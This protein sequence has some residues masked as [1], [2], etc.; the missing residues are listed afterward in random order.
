L[1]NSVV[2]WYETTFKALLTAKKYKLA[3]QFLNNTNCQCGA[4]STLAYGVCSD[5][6]SKI[7]HAKKS[8]VLYGAMST[9]IEELRTDIAQFLWDEGVR[10]D[11]NEV[12]YH[13]A[14]SRI[15]DHT[16]EELSSTVKWLRNLSIEVQL[17][18]VY[19]AA[20]GCSISYVGSE[21]SRQYMPTGREHSLDIIKWL[22]SQ[23][24][25]FP[26][27]DDAPS[28]FVTSNDILE[29]YISIGEK[30]EESHLEFAARY[31]HA[32]VPIITR[33]V[34]MTPKIA[35]IMLQH[36]KLLLEPGGE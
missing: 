28:Y 23:R 5:H 35:N 16:V 4:K 20:A 25:P 2:P 1:L 26:Y 8:K 3:L 31:N 21:V 22:Y 10:I 29:W 33:Y 32:A 11:V 18:V 14:R 7:Y 13:L 17:G 30:I 36:G 15:C 24:V 27:D 19:L 9:A 34:A 6:V 12:Q